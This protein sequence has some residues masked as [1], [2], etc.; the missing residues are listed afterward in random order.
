MVFLRKWLKNDN[1]FF[2]HSRILKRHSHVF[3]T[4]CMVFVWL[5]FVRWLPC[6]L[7]NESSSIF[8]AD[9]EEVFACRACASTLFV[10]HTL[11]KLSNL[12]GNSK[13]FRKNFELFFLIW[14]SFHICLSDSCKSDQNL[15]E[16][17]AFLGYFHQYSRTKWRKFRI[18]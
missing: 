18:S 16:F 12:S 7:A 9:V 11:I 1:Q 6:E 13:L 15:G 2:S 17:S 10:Y 4:I 5:T 3:L 14:F 8:T